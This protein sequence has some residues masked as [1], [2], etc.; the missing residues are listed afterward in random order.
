VFKH[1]IFSVF[2]LS[3]CLTG[4]A[5]AQTDPATPTL[6]FTIVPLTVEKGFPLH[7]ILTEKL[8]FKLH[9][10]VH[11]RILEPVYAFD[12]EVIP[13][14]T[15]VV[16]TIT[17]FQSR[18]KWKRVSSILGGDF[19]PVRYPLI[20]FDTLVLEDGTRV[21]I[22]TSVEP[23]TDTLV[24]FNGEAKEN[25]DSVKPHLP[26]TV[27]MKAIRDAGKQSG[28]ELFKGMLWNLAPYHPQ[29]LPSGLRYKATL[30]RPL[31]F[32]NAILG[33]G[34]LDRVGTDAPAGSVI[35][36]RLETPLNS[37]STKPGATVT[38]LLT[39]P[40]FSWDHLLIFPVGSRLVGEVVQVR[41]AG[42]LQHTGQMGFKFTQIET[43]VSV[44]SGRRPPQ[45]IEG[46]LL[47]VQVGDAMNR[48]RIDEDGAMSI[49]L[50]K[51]RFVAPALALFNMSRGFN[52]SSESFGHAVT[53]A[54]TGSM[55]N[56]L[57]VGNSGLG[58]SAG[59]AGRMIPPV[60][61]S[62]GIFNAARSV[63]TNILARGQE[64][65]FPLDTPIEI[66]L[67]TQ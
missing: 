20:S 7:V 6:R 43:P 67:D 54:Y 18:G 10:E 37:R 11:G 57:L 28:S 47:A 64:I 59:I 62:L 38:A 49:A 13:P 46:H 22:E 31:D 42:R 44:L 40:V 52:T 34:A 41:P 48:A 33:S 9:E 53:G 17:G 1:H 61:L 21:P 16:G 12:R 60:G 2:L 3:A 55:I 8:H 19:T 26:E 65:N 14:G 39:N 51:T 36:A 29:S 15:E 45:D 30:L 66:R 4:A 50:S 24:Q 23:G 63:F 25:K 5:Y 32:G 58:L 27:Q 56:R 35:Y